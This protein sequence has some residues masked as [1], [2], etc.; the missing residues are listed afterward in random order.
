MGEI[1]V[2]SLQE[3]SAGVE[4]VSLLQRTVP[5]ITEVT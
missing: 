3:L 5:R 2:L 4:I 1:P